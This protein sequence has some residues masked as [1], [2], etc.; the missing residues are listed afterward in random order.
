MAMTIDRPAAA[1]AISL[2][3]GIFVLLAGIVLGVIG[4]VVT[5][6][7]GGIGAA[8]GIIGVLWGSLIIIAAIM[9]FERPQEHQIWSVLIL[10]FSI[11]SWVGAIGGFVIGFILGL[12]GGILGLIWAPS[13]TRYN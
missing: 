4:F 12:T 11:L 3:G 7:I 10:V 1:F 6:P 2:I 8:L 9:M 13:E 5:I